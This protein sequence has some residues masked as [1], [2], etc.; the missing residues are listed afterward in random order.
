M[1]DESFKQIGESLGIGAGGLIALRL[2]WWFLSKISV[3]KSDSSEKIN[4]I[5]RVQNATIEDIKED[6][7]VFAQFMEEFSD[8]VARLDTIES[9]SNDFKQEVEN[10]FKI[11][12]E[13][14][15][16]L[17]NNQSKQGI[18]LDHFDSY[19][20]AT[21]N[22]MKEDIKGLKRSTDKTNDL[23]LKMN[24]NISLIMGKL[25]GI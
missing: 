19:F 10:A 11:G 20:G 1:E 25:G 24:N 21:I 7:E 3:G 22:P 16:N 2:G 12:D 8:M 5:T 15:E 4:E 17:N 6:R 18:R 14:M 13:N 23:L 9:S